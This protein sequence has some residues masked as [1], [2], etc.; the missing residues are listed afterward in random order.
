MDEDESGARDHQEIR[1]G[2][3]TDSRATGCQTHA[4]IGTLTAA[5]SGIVIAAS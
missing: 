5:P 3:G 1:D 2:D 4:T